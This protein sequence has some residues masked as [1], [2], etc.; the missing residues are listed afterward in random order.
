MLFGLVPLRFLPGARIKSWSWIAWTA[1]FVVVLYVFVHVLLM[2]ESG[3]LGRSTAASVSLT[4]ALFAA[5]AV[6]SVAFWGYFRWRPTP[7]IPDGTAAPDDTV[8]VSGAE[9]DAGPPPRQQVPVDSHG[10]VVPGQAPHVPQQ[11]SSSTGEPS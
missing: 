7:A 1:L 9:A 2:P 10:D 5:F 11:K 8:L 6:I 3:Y 4:V